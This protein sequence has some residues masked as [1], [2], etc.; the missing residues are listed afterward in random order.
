MLKYAK[1]FLSLET[2]QKIFLGIVEPHIR[3]CCSVWGCAGD[4]IL[5]KLQK[6]QNRAAPSLQTVLFDKALLPLI[7]NLGD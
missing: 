5:Q 3:H 4:A 2:V 7:L 6:I 1:K